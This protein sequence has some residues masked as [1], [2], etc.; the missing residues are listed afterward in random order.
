MLQLH[1]MKGLWWAV[2]LEKF[3]K[4]NIDT[5]TTDIMVKDPWELFPS[6]FSYVTGSYTTASVRPSWKLKATYGI[7][8][9]IGVKRRILNKKELKLY[10]LTNRQEA[11]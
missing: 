7:E 9:V 6:R 8:G 10:G 2:T 11:A 3:D 1:R 5:K 4:D